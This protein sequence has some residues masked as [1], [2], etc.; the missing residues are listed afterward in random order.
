MVGW[1]GFFQ[2]SE[3]NHIGVHKPPVMG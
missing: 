1:I 2:D 3:G